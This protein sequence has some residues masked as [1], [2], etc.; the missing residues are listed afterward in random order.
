[1]RMEISVE[2]FMDIDLSAP[3]HQQ[4]RSVSSIRPKD[5]RRNTTQ[6]EL[7]EHLRANEFFEIKEQ[8]AVKTLDDILDAS[9]HAP[10]SAFTDHAF[11]GRLGN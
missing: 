7:P 8:S 1:M 6:P 10:V 3:S 2:S 11:A 9:A 5:V 4:S